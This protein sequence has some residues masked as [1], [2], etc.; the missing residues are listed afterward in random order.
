MKI[1]FSKDEIKL[2]YDA[3]ELYPHEIQRIK[4]TYELE[5]SPFEKEE[6]QQLIDE[7]DEKLNLNLKLFKRLRKKLEEWN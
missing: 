2:I 5:P 3:L 4:I 1:A 6:Q 7:C